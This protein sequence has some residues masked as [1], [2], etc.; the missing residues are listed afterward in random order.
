MKS[1]RSSSTL[2]L[3]VDQ[4]F[5]RYCQDVTSRRVPEAD[6]V[7]ELLKGLALLSINP[8]QKQLGDSAML[9]GVTW[10]YDGAQ[11]HHESLS[12]RQ[13]DTI[14]LSASDTAQDAQDAPV[15]STKREGSWKDAQQHTGNGAPVR[16]NAVKQKAQPLKWVSKPARRRTE[17][18]GKTT[19][20]TS[21]RRKQ[22]VT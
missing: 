9:K 5:N 17:K 13:E 18:E 19:S 14:D 8:K 2:S 11:P 4:V 22:R 21:Q 16:Q 15:A 3:P 20:V 12:T 10:A 7:E 1:L 6:F